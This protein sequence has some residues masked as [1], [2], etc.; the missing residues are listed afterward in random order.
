[1]RTIVVKNNRCARF[2][3]LFRKIFQK[4]E[5]H[6]SENSFGWAHDIAIMTMASVHQLAVEIRMPEVLQCRK[7][8]HDLLIAPIDIV[9]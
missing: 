5:N 6:F 2:L 1:M 8:Q 7:N 3:K 4:I 9:V